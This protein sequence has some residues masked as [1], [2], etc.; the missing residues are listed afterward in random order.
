[1]RE[2]SCKCKK[3]FI[4][5]PNPLKYQYTGSNVIP[6]TLTHFCDIFQKFLKIGFIS[7]LGCFDKVAISHSVNRIFCLM[8]N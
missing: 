3:H 1:M 5:E 6:V 4:F 8:I 7:S 2:F